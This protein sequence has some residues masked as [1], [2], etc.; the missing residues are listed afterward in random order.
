M[1]FHERM[2]ASSGDD[3]TLVVEAAAF[4]SIGGQKYRR[5]G[6]GSAMAEMMIDWASQ[7]G[8]VK[9][10][11]FGVTAGLFPGDWMDSCMPPRPFWQNFGFQVIGQTKIHQSLRDIINI[12]GEDDPRN[13]EAERRQKQEIKAQLQQGLILEEE[14]AYDFDLEKNLSG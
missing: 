12:V 1:L 4:C 3:K 11:I 7:T 10:Q 5:H 6:I 13:S 8:W 14:W 2:S 9:M